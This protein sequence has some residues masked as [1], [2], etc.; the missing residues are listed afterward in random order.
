[1]EPGCVAAHHIKHEDAFEL[2]QVAVLLGLIWSSRHTRRLIHLQRYRHSVR[3]LG[4][5]E[6]L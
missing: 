1:M 5:L 3:V 6:L 2:N 4:L